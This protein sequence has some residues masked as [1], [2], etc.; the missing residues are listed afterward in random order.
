MK[1][2]LLPRQLGQNSHHKVDFDEQQQTLY[3]H[4]NM[5]ICGLVFLDTHF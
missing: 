4:N 3:G 1:K 2:L 5:M